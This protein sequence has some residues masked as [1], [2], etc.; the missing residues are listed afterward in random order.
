MV[1]FEG[2]A[3]KKAHYRKFTVKGTQGQ[4]DFASMHEV[5]GRR[6]ALRYSDDQGVDYDA[7]FEAVPDLVLIDG[8]KGQLNAAVAAL[9]LAGLQDAVPVVSL[10]KREEEVFTTWSEAP[11]VLPPDD[12]GRLLLQRVRDEAHRFAVGFHRSKRA[13]KTTESFLDQLPGV[14]E[15]RKKAIMQ[16]FGSPDRFLQASCEELEA[17]PGLPAKIAREIYAYVHK[18]G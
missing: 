14:G 13:A 3:P 1:V 4:D 7:S 5:V 18:S 15:K 6:F 9:A 2:G 12:P 11:V 17:V 16:H 8:G 10:A